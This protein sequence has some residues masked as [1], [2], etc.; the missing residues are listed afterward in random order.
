VPL[1]V[2]LK[3]IVTAE[4][5]CART[6]DAVNAKAPVTKVHPMTNPRSLFTVVSPVD[7]APQKGRFVV[8]RP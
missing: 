8:R 1:T 6:G 7:P 3:V 4:E 5:V 2:S